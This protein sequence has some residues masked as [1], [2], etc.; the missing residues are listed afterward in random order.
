MTTRHRDYSRP[1]DT[2]SVRDRMNN[3]NSERAPRSY[4]PHSAQIPLDIGR[5]DPCTR[6]AGNY[7]CRCGRCW[8]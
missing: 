5:V 2:D 8:R 3:Y 4:T 7:M 1:M 6:Y